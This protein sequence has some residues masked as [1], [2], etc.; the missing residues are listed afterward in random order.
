MRQFVSRFLVWPA[1]R[2]RVVWPLLARLPK[3]LAYRLADRIGRLDWAAD[4][5]LAPLRVMQW[6]EAVQQ[7]FPDMPPSTVDQMGAQNACLIAFDTLDA[8]RLARLGA[9]DIRA[10][11]VISGLEHLHAAKSNGRGVVLAIAHH[12]RF[13]ALAPGLGGNGE[14][15][16]MLTTP[17]DSSNPAYS[18]PV[19]FRY[20]SR[21]MQDTVAHSKGSW[22]TTRDSLREVYRLLKQGQVVLVAFDGNE[23]IG[24]RERYSFLGGDLN[25]PQGMLRLLEA[26]QASAVYASVHSQHETPWRVEIRIRPLAEQPQEAMRQAVVYLENDLRQDPSAWWQWRALSVFREH[27]QNRS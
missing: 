14:P 20:W 6:R 7:C 21:K 5:H 2:H 1:F 9:D 26:T 17:I 4:F 22:V 24:P 19:S 23:S 18:D 12:D 15:F 3:S 11:F 25:L 8:Y 13:F 16:A 27:P 10:Q